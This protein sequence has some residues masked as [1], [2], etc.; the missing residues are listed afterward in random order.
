MRCSWTIL[1]SVVAAL[2]AVAAGMEIPQRWVLQELSHPDAYSFSISDI[3]DAGAVT[4]STYST[5]PDILYQPY[6]WQDGEVHLVPT[7]A[8]WTKG[9][10]INEAGLCL[11]VDIDVDHALHYSVDGIT[12]LGYIADLFGS[13][14]YMHGM[15]ESGQFIGYRP[16]GAGVFQAITWDKNLGVVH[17][18]PDQTHSYGFDINDA[19]VAVGYWS[20]SGSNTAFMYQD[21][22]RTDFGLSWA[23][24]T[25]AY[26]IDNA[27]RILV[28]QYLAGSTSYFMV[29]STDFSSVQVAYFSNDETNSYAIANETGQVAFSWDTHDGSSFMGHLG[30]WS[31]ED[32]FVELQV[33]DDS[34]GIMLRTI[35]DSGWILGSSHDSDY[36]LQTF[37]TSAGNELRIVDDRVIGQESIFMVTASDMNASGQIGTMLNFWGGDDM[38]VVLSP[39]RAGDSNGDGLVNITDLLLIIGLWGD[40]PVGGI[41]GP[42][43]DMNGLINVNDLLL[44]ISDWG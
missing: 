37:V 31:V 33:P 35:N 28:R 34:I 7:T 15:N 21:G 11:G 44:C 3:N 32:G 16:L 42:D 29:D 22:K 6:I 12:D 39:A 38:T 19:G 10:H 13:G 26:A 18:T 40:W 24:S 1:L 17:I 41:C 14:L 25:R 27:G 36:N 2:S 30:W 23:G 5:D 20:V 43:L 8:Y 4:G 9:Y